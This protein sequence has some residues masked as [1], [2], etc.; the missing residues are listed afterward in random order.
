VVPSGEVETFATLGGPA[1]D[2]RAREMRE[3]A[4][5]LGREVE[6]TRQAAPGIPVEVRI[7]SGVP[8]REICRT[9]EEKN[10]DLIVIATHGRTGISHLLLGSTAERVVQ[11][12]PCPVLSFK[13]KIVQDVSEKELDM[14]RPLG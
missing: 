11:L 14:P 10:C 1:E 5:A 3:A 8:F 7:S 6:R 4:A 2:L 13:P 12:A 9:A